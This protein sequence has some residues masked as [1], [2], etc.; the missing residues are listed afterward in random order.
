MGRLEVITGSMFS[1]KTSE[2]IRRLR[3]CLVARKKVQAFKSVRD[4]RYHE[5]AI[6]SH[7]RTEVSS[8]AVSQ[9]SEILERFDGLAQVVGIDEAQFF[10]TD[11]VG[12]CETLARRGC[13]V[14]VA[15][16]DMDYRGEPFEV[17]AN[18]MARAE[19]VTKNLAIC[20]RCGEEAHYSQ[21]LSGAETASGRILVGA[22]ESYE[23]RCRK[24]FEPPLFPR[25][26]PTLAP[27]S[28][29]RGG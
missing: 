15:G 6:V 12:V 7:D 11:L 22:K 20:S 9:A 8:L 19:L 29:E 13:R 24:C 14:I 10:G 17:I 27:H 1:G 21:L 16:L 2:L 28:G 5:T 25:P 3:L 4:R 23:A 26:A 18:L